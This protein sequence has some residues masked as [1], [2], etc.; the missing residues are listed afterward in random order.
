MGFG[1]QPFQ[2]YNNTGMGYM[3]INPN[4]AMQESIIMD[5]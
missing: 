1:N 4:F 5:R 2:D 3:S